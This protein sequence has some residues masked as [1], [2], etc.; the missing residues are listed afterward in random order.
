M[1]QIVPVT[2]NPNQTLTVS[3]NVDGGVVT[4]QLTVRYF[5]LCGYWVMT[6]KDATGNLLLDSIPMLCGVYPAA[7]ILA[8]YAYLQIGSAF[9]VNVS[10][11]TQDSP[12]AS[13]L[14]TD[15]LLL[16]DDNPTS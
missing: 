9:L 6:I 3:L 10:N 2:G 15:F 1:A 8:Q 16:W 7:N 5:D 11:T 13:S 12:G 4:L 14:G